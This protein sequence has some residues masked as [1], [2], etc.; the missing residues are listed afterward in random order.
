M[1]LK[2]ESR[3][4]REIPINLDMQITPPKGR[5]Q[6]GTKEPLYESERGE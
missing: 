4:P 3:L 2:L 1:K 5:K 6:G